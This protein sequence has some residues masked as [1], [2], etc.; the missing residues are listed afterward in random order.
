[1]GLRYFLPQAACFALAKLSMTA[2]P[3]SVPKPPVRGLG[4]S[5]S[6]HILRFKTIAVFETICGSSV[7]SF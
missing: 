1:M 2:E 4:W 5:R 7:C 3:R 6:E